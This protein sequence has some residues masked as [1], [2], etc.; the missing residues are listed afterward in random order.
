[1]DQESW[2]SSVAI[3]SSENFALKLAR[4][5]NDIAMSFGDHL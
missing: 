1:M 2:K 3:A 4:E 5:T